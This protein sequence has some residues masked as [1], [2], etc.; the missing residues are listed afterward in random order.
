DNTLLNV[1]KNEKVTVLIGTSG[2]PG[3]FTKQIV[4]AVGENTDRPVILPLSNPTAK[5]EALPKDIYEWTDGKALV[6]TG[7]P[8]DPVNYKGKSYRIGQMN[9]A[10]IFPGV[11]LGIVASGATEVLPVFFS[12]AAH[13]ITEFISQ[14]D[15]NDG[16]LFPPL[17]QL[18]QVSLEVAKRVG[19]EAIKADIT[20]KGCAFAKFKHN[21]DPERLNMIVEKMC[22]DPKYLEQ[23]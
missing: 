18:R 9:N 3:C 6:A 19:A 16:I 15:I 20:G 8:F 21:N 2:Q 10:F 14:E 11:G 23:I 17:D 7:S 12:A 22:W 13:A 4:T 1:I 5:T